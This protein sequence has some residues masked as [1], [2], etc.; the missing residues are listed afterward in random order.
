MTF[1]LYKEGTWYLSLTER[2]ESMGQWCRPCMFDHGCRWHCECVQND[3]I[4]WHRIWSCCYF[5]GPNGVHHHTRRVRKPYISSGL[6]PFSA[7]DELN[8]FEI[9]IDLDEIVPEGA[10]IQ[11]YEYE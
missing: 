1:T 4:W 3:V 11:G 8:D 2:D 10:E 5:Y 9:T 6:H 7:D